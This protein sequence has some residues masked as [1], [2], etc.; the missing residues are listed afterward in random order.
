M[1]AKNLV[2]D[3]PA[4]STDE[5]ESLEREQRIARYCADRMGADEAAAFEAE[6]LSDSLLASD[7]QA[8]MLL[9]DACAR[10]TNP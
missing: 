6:L 10:G 3:K 5:R 8:A 9:R 7:V 4:P 2:P 1:I